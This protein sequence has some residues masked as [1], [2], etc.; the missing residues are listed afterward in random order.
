MASSLSP[1]S[2][3]RCVCIERNKGEA[4]AKTQLSKADK[5][6]KL[7]H[8]STSEIARLTGENPAYVSTVRSRTSADGHPID[9]A[10]DRNWRAS[11]RDR[12]TEYARLS[13]RR[14]RAADP[15]KAAARRKA[16]WQRKKE[17]YH[18]EP[19]YADKLLDCNAK[20]RAKRRAEAR[21]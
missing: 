8:L 6:R 4:M 9:R 19:G 3:P 18:S 1:Q 13:Q 21:A 14:I 17:R 12:V 15:E 11:N 10:S 5:I 7:L 16:D 20:Y 2:E